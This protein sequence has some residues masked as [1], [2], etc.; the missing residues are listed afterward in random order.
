MKKVSEKVE[1]DDD[2]DYDDEEKN[3]MMMLGNNEEKMIQARVK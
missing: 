3:E 2:I 1:L